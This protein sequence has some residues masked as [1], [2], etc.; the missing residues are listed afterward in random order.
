MATS[1]MHVS[2]TRLA[3]LLGDFDTSPAW[4]GLAEALR[5]LVCDGRLPHGTR[6]PSE[7][8][9]AEVL[10]VSRTTVTRA[11]DQL[12]TSGWAVAR[13]GAGTWT[14]IPGGPRH[15]VDRTLSPRGPD[16][17]LIDLTC[18]ATAAPAG[19]AAAYERA[20]G[21]LPGLLADHGYFPAGLPELTSR[22]AEQFT[23]DGLATDPGQV[24]VTPGALAATAVTAHALLKVG[25]RVLVESPV[26]P[27]APA[28]L[29]LRGCRLV[30]QPV[31][32]R[33]PAGLDATLRSSGIRAAYLC[34][35]FQNPTGV[36]L[37]DTERADLAAVLARHDVLAVVDESHRGLVLDSSGLPGGRMPLPFAAHVARAG[38]R[39]V[40]VGGAS[41]T[42]WG[43]LRLGWLRAEE[44]DLDVLTDARLALDLGTPV[45]EQMVLAD[46][47]GDPEVLAG[48]LAALRGQ[49]DALVAR[50][51]ER[52]PTWEFTVPVGGMVLWCRLPGPWAVRF[53]ELAEAE[54]VALTPGPVF[55]TEGGARDRVR[56][57]WT[58]PVPVLDEAVDRLARAWDRLGDRSTGSADGIPG[59]AAARPVVVA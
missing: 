29:R 14:R 59:A 53:A 32:S 49:R 33:D 47:L 7:R 17:D 12:R 31:A 58:L 16:P 6:L 9:L 26:Y 43:G 57:P 39:A 11:Y 21:Q 20:V 54:G 44:A 45:T 18:A 28:S 50:V 19:V 38:G 3:S 48:H 55:D 51:R 52:L 56:L 15:G 35:D 10:P 8:D 41:K 25:D 1:S 27:N 24:M 4:A 40:T 5:M 13:V 36:L 22:I 2:P 42:V 34:P 37:D 23:A 46:L 30:P